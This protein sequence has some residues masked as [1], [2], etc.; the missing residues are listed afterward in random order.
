MSQNP[1]PI[2][3]AREHAFRLGDA[4]VRPA[5]LQLDVDG[6]STGL[7]PRMMQ[8]LVLLCRR[9][10]EVVSRDELIAACWHGRIVGEDAIERCIG[11]LRRIGSETG[12]FAVETVPRVGYR[13]SLG[14]A[15]GPATTPGP[16]LAVL[17]FDNLS[18]NSDLDY[19]SDGFSDEVLR[20]LTRSTLRVIGR[21]SAFAFR[22]AA[23]ANAAHALRAA[24]L[25]DGTVRRSGDRVRITANLVDAESGIALWS[26]AFDHDEADLFDT[27]LAIASQVASALQNQLTAPERPAADAHAYDLY[28]RGMHLSYRG[29]VE[30]FRR[31]ELLFTEAVARAPEFASAWAGL[32]STRAVLAEDQ[33]A[34]EGSASHDAALA[35]VRRAVALDPHCAMAYRI[36]ALLTRSLGQYDEKIALAR[37]ALLEGPTEPFSLAQMAAAQVAVGRVS[38]GL[39]YALKASELEPLSP[40]F[41]VGAVLYL[42]ACGRAEEARRLLSDVKARHAPSPW[43]DLAEGALPDAQRDQSATVANLES[44]V[45]LIAH[46]SSLR[47]SEREAFLSAALA[48]TKAL[49]LPI[50]FASARFGFTDLAYQHLFGALDSGRPLVVTGAMRSGVNRAFITCTFFMGESAALRR[51]ARFAE[52]CARVGL[53]DHWVRSGQWPDCVHELAP[54]YDF[55][56][57]CLAL[58]ELSDR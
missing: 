6:T 40:M 38:E 44:R 51:D 48:Q 27:Q 3:L 15:R 4:Y 42:Q 1:S 7:Q 50:C 56:D 23:K 19:F 5:R 57:A 52:L 35:A 36:E 2:V 25:L 14:A 49:P 55:R 13:L 21:P 32:A 58:P 33:D 12:A 20:L 26:D 34:W 47:H 10:G 53:V 29:T 17:P 8:T 54:Y 46:M 9:I 16:I 45:G 30:D 24:Y 31:A 43:L 22:G 28:L 11:K 41:A 39:P 37:R 18:Q